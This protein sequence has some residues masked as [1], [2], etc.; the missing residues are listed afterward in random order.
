MHIP[1]DRTTFFG[2]IQLFSGA[3]LVNFVGVDQAIGHHKFTSIV[4][5]LRAI[6]F[7]FYNEDGSDYHFVGVD[8]TAFLEVT[9]LDSNTGS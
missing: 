5:R 3:D 1:N 2:R 9:T 7:R 8:Y 4:K 6:R